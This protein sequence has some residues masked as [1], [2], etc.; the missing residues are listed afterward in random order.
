M[1]KHRTVLAI[2]VSI[3]SVLASI[4]EAGDACCKAEAARR[5]LQVSDPFAKKPAFWDDEDDGPWE[6]PMIAMV[7]LPGWYRLVHETKLGLEGAAPWLIAGVLTAALMTTIAKPL[8][9]SSVLQSVLGNHK[10]GE[11]LTATRAAFDSLRGAVFGLLMPFCSCGALPLAVAL[12]REGVSPPSI[13]AFVTAAQAAGI[14]SLL[15]THSVFGVRV[16]LLRLLAAG[17]LAFLVG[18]AVAKCNEVA[19]ESSRNSP[20]AAQDKS[21][22]SCCDKEASS[23]G[24]SEGTL[25][26]SQNNITNSI[27]LFFRTSVELFSSVALWVFLGAVVSACASIW[28]P[29]SGASS[30]WSLANTMLGRAGLLLLSLPVTIC[31]HGIVSLARALRGIGVSAGTAAALVVTGPATNAG[32]L[33]LLSRLNNEDARNSWWMRDAAKM[34]AV[35][36]AFGV[37]L[38]FLADE[39]GT[40][41]LEA[42]STAGAGGG[43]G[44]PEWLGN[45]K[46]SL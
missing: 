42:T 24:C 18:M 19:P 29:V 11:R 39:L 41:A 1:N 40:S 34:A 7:D 15:F 6:A 8:L 38:S 10:A 30:P 14:D 17:F 28:A 16:A 13:A 3:L 26:R 35:I 9:P 23:S 32:T 20:N 25:T 37:A 31:E 21:K 46:S 5:A 33:L 45:N 2:T 22:G 27:A 44:L 12:R 36:L 4:A 43:S